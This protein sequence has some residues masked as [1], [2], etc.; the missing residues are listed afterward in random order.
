MKALAVFDF[1]D[2]LATTDSL[3][4]VEC[5]EEIDFA[6]KLREHDISVKHTAGGFCWIDSK[7]YG[8][9]ELTGLPEEYHLVFDY[10]Q[11]MSVNIGNTVPIKPMLDRM[12][13]AVADPDTLVLVLTARA[14]YSTVWS[15]FLKR[16]VVATNREQ[17]R[18]FLSLH[19]IEL[20]EHFLHTVGDVGDHGGDTALAKGEVLKGY[21]LQY[22]DASIDF[23]DDSE[24]NLQAV[25]SIC[26]VGLYKNKITAHKVDSGRVVVTKSCYCKRGIKERVSSIFSCMLE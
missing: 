6:E 15:P 9:L 7:D 11:T 17:I 18:R 3:I 14:G 25:L 4:G 21:C 19:G 24:R 20:Q 16:N 26:Q 13:A 12:K 1:D 2:T 10:N 8:K 5:K 23:Y 22:P